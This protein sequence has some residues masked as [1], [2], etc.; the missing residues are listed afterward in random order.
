[1]IDSTNRRREIQKNNNDEPSITPRTIYK[2]AE[3][4]MQ[5]TR[6]ADAKADKYGVEKRSEDT[7]K[8]S[9]AEWS[10]MTPFAREEMLDR[11]EKEMLDASKKLDFE[12]AA[13]LRD[14][15]ERLK[16]GKKKGRVKYQ[17]AKKT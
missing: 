3:E 9:D 17:F 2:S 6:V 13:E 8:I 7:L 11:L 5:S 1:M 10:K 4:I 15:I 12:R 14:E 16:S